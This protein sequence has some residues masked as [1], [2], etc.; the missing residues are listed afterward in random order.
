M[1]SADRS[2]PVG[3]KI[4]DDAI[5]AWPFIA[6]LALALVG[7]GYLLTASLIL[8]ARL[9]MPPKL[10]GPCPAITILKPL[11]GAEPGLSENLATF[12]TQEYAGPVQILFG[13]QDPM[14]P[15]IAVVRKLIAD[16]P[17]RDL[18]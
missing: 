10:A 7:C 17:W 18:E 14:D 1:V 16:Y 4:M 12:C 8:S 13:T 3:L 6:C 11:H 15:A 5:V 2:V 9:R